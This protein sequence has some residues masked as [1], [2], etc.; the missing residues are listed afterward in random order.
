MRNVIAVTVFRPISLKFSK[1]SFF[2]F[3]Y[4]IYGMRGDP[5]LKKSK[6]DH[7]QAKKSIPMLLCPENMITRLSCIETF[8]SLFQTMYFLSSMIYFH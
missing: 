7:P 6:I 2:V 5:S 3:A 4:D 8:D 1:N